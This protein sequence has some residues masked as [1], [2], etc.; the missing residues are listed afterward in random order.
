M[1]AVCEKLIM[2]HVGI[3]YNQHQSHS[4]LQRFKEALAAMLPRL[5][6]N[7]DGLD[8]IVGELTDQPIPKPMPRTR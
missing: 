6:D 7:L 3:V 2:R 5:Q 1:L 4:H 8:W